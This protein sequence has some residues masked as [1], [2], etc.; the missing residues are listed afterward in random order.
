[1]NQGTGKL[2]FISGAAGGLGQK[3]AELFFQQ[4]YRLWLTDKD[5]ETLK[6]LANKFSDT[7]IT[8][9]DLTNS[10]QLEQL[11]IS[12][13]E[14]KEALEL[15]YINAGISLP[16]KVVD[17]TRRAI[18][19]QLDINLKAAAHLNHAVAKKMCQQKQGHIINTLSTAAMIS[20]Q[21]GA[22]YS[23]SKFGLRGF[24][25]ALAA[26]L[27][28]EGV[29]VSGIYPNAIDTPML[30]Y[31]AVNGGSSLNFL[32]EPITPD[33]IMNAIKKA[34]KGKKLE[35]FVP[36]KDSL[37]AKLICAFP[38]VLNRLYPLLDKMGEKGR[39]KYIKSRGL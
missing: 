36:S 30:R 12:L 18:D 29:H 31:E 7:K 24:L 27:K 37:T 11:C 39:L 22:A 33:D 17:S 3:A 4:G 10:E 34:Q 6:T 5:E 15:A 21:E 16:G 20:L 23:A 1:M 25:I 26:E 13:E 2:A 9:A 35:Y 28:H 14:N 32:D 38:S 19:L 8:V